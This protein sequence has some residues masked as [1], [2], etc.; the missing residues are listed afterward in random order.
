MQT[1]ANTCFAPLLNEDEE[2]LIS[3]YRRCND[4]GCQQ[5]VTFAELFAAQADPLPDNVVPFPQ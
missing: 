5:L 1:R 3:L 4:I 2:R